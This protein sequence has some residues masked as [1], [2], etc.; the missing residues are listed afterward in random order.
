MSLRDGSFSS[1]FQSLVLESLILVPVLEPF[2]TSLLSW[3]FQQHSFHVLASTPFIHTCSGTFAPVI[4][5]IYVSGGVLN[6]THSLSG[7]F[8]VAVT[9]FVTSPK[10]QLRWA[11]DSTG[12]GDDLW[13]V[14]N[15]SI[16]PGN[17]AWPSLHGYAQWIPEMVSSHLRE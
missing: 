15:P 12:V 14:Y 5:P 7:W 8:G 9:A 1:H 13:R 6:P 17:S 4:W 11:P 16:H 10:L 3:S 2:L